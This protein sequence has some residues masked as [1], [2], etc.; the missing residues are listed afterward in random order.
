MP[1]FHDKPATDSDSEQH[2]DKEKDQKRPE[3]ETDSTPGK[4]EEKPKP[5]EKKDKPGIDNMA[6]TK[7]KGDDE[8][9]KAMN[10]IF[11][12]FNN[13]TS[14]FRFTSDKIETVKTDEKPEDSVDGGAD[15]ATKNDEP[16][17]VE[18]EENTSLPVTE[19]E[20][21][22]ENEEEDEKSIE[23]NEKSTTDLND[24]ENQSTNIPEPTISVPEVTTI[25]TAPEPSEPENKPVE[26]RKKGDKATSHSDN[27]LFFAGATLSSPE[28]ELKRRHSTDFVSVPR[29]LNEELI[30]QDM[31][32]KG[33]PFKRRSTKKTIPQG[34][35]GKIISRAIFMSARVACLNLL[36]PSPPPIPFPFPSS[37][38]SP[39]TPC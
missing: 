12:S 38:P 24:K 37:S 1:R 30:Q 16:N 36:F 6:F 20:G 14:K 7:T 2:P 31:E 22:Q 13:F 29:P 34:T 11:Q 15:E 5:I 35:R 28:L 39:Q 23:S 25:V 10:S 26:K 8:E 32:R 27:M 19:I 33:I 4:K 21:N 17:S 18:S 3:S 9:E